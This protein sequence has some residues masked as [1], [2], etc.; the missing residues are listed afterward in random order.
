MSKDKDHFAYF[1]VSKSSDAPLRSFAFGKKEYLEDVRKRWADASQR[2]DDSAVLKKASAKEDFPQDPDFTHASALTEALSASVDFGLAQHELIEAATLAP[3]MMRVGM[4]E[5]HVIRPTINNSTLIDEDDTSIVHGLSEHQ[6]ADLVKREGKYALAIKGMERFPTASL[7][8]IVATFDTLIVDVL[9]SMLKL[10]TDWLEK[11]QRTISLD[12]L[13]KASS[14]DEL[15]DEQ[16]EEEIYSFSRE[17]HSKQASYIKANFGI[18]IPKDWKRWPDY[19]EI[20]ERRN[21]VAHGE[22]VFNKRYVEICIREGHKG[23]EKIIGNEV[24][25]SRDYLKQS[26]DV[27]IEFGLLLPF[28]LF[29]R[30][31]RENEDQAFVNLNEAVFKLMSNG[32]FVAAER[33]SKF[34]LG[35]QKVKITNETKLMLLVNQASALRHMGKLEESKNILDGTDWTAVSDLFKICVAS[36]RGDIDEFVR[37]VPVLK[38]GGIL[39]GRSVLQWPCFAFMLAERRAQDIMTS[40]FGLDFDQN[41][42]EIPSEGGDIPVLQGQAETTH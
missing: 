42:E 9:K 27:L 7:L 18:D 6:Y 39:T 26:L 31:V 30:F 4:A 40:E 34:A 8:S 12:R 38:A 14:I 17:S 22:G 21:L 25:I 19:I 3:L 28:H 16:V 15:I 5:M 32:H 24:I 20:F 33:V 23:S 2:D 41:V 35:L 29:R 37:L 1:L 11:S 36:V 13:S 10:Q